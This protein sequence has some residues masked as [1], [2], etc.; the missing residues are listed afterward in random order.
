MSNIY[1]IQVSSEDNDAV[2]IYEHAL[3]K[4]ED[5]QRVYKHAM[6]QFPN[7]EVVFAEVPLDTSPENALSI[8]NLC[9]GNT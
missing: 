6:R 8:L 9:R 4:H 1:L 2:I 3:T 5:A 7:S